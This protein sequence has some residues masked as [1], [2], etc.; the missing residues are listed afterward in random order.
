MIVRRSW[1]GGFAAALGVV[2]LALSVAPST[3]HASPEAE[4]AE[5]RLRGCLLAGASAAP[6]SGLE[7]AVIAV[8]SFCAPQIKRVRE[9]RVDTATQGL[10]GDAAKAAEVRAIRTLNDEIALAIAN[11]TGLTF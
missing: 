7:A 5:Q 3:T 8:R 2:V 4:L 1:R 11:F 10:K 9:D 6:R